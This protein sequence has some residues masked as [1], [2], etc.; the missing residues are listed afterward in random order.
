[1]REAG[2]FGAWLARAPAR[3]E[4]DGRALT[5]SSYG[6]SAGLLKIPRAAFGTRAGEREV[7]IVPGRGR[8]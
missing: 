5:P 8:P 2:D 6:Y 3:V 7:R 1:L 4:V